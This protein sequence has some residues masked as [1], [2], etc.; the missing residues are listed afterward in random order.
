MPENGDQAFHVSDSS[1]AGRQADPVYVSRSASSFAAA[2]TR[3][4][5]AGAAQR[6]ARWRRLLR[7]PLHNAR[8]MVRWFLMTLKIQFGSARVVAAQKTF[9]KNAGGRFAGKHQLR[10]LRHVG[11]TNAMLGLIAP[12]EGH[13]GCGIGPA[14]PSARS[15][16]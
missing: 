14:G 3:A 2:T 15:R 16:W 6:Q 9:E 10:G 1:T 8:T 11:R 7:S 4:S 13:A 12:E 5:R